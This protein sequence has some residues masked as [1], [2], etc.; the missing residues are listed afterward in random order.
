M[1]KNKLDVIFYHIEKTAGSSLRDYLY[2]YLCKI[3]EKEHI[4]YEEIIPKH[5]LNNHEYI[6]NTYKVVL[7]HVY[8]S[9]IFNKNDI[10]VFNVYGIMYR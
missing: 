8:F 5:I 4:L 3:Y 7:N 10:I 9:D 1:E 6:S 2:N